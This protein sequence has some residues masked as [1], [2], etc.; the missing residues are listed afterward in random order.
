M[1]PALFIQTCSFVFLKDASIEKKETLY[2]G[3]FFRAITYMNN[4]RA[5]EGECVCVTWLQYNKPLWSFRTGVG[6]GACL[7]IPCS[8]DHL[9]LKLL[10]KSCVFKAAC[11]KKP[12]LATT[13]TYQAISLT[14][15]LIHSGSDH[16]PR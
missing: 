7:W 15:S 14:R 4:E 11:V 13:L 12:T 9:T 1:T 8:V 2:L 10:M 6:G 5:L 16:K 3:V